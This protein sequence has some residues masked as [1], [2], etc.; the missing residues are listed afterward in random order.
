[1][2]IPAGRHTLG[3]D[4]ATLSIKTQR[5]GAAAKAGHNLLI[6]VAGWSAALEVGE[7]T[8]IELRADATSL[9]VI[10][11]TGG[12]QTLGDE[13]RASILQSIDD[14]VLKRQEITF[15]STEVTAGDNG[16]LGVQGDLTLVGTTHP[17][18]FDL[19]VADGRLNASAI[20][21]QSDWGIK[22][23]SIL[24]GTLKVVDDVEVVFEGSLAS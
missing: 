17:I 14:D 18:S 8:S 20:V 5:T 3:P 15:G 13:E 2:A 6:E 11:G 16:T 12:L 10:E 19:H 23:F 1:M 7:Q 9:R 21:T 24:F 22:P 4:T